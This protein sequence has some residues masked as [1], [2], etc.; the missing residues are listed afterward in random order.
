[1]AISQIALAFPEAARAASHAS[2]RA[3]GRASSRCVGDAGRAFV[4]ALAL[5]V[6]PAAT[7]S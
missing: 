4:I 3:A 5:S 7:F 2:S 6:R 1:M